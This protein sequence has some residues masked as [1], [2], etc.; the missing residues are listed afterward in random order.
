VWKCESCGEKIVI[1]S[2]RELGREKNVFF[3]ARHGEAGS[4]VRGIVSSYPEPQPFD[5]TEQGVREALRLAE[6]LKSRGGIDAIYASD[7]LR[8]KRTA[9][10][11]GG[12]LGIPVKFDS[13]LREYN[14]GIWNGKTTAEFQRGFPEAKRWHGAPEGGETQIE[15]ERRMASFVEE[16]NAAFDG[17]R[18][19][20]VS[21]G[22]PLMMLQRH[23]GS[24]RPY[25]NFADPFTLDVGVPDVH[26][27][28]IDEILLPCR[29]CGKKARRVSEIF[30]SWV[31]AGS[32]PFAEYHY[33]FDQKTV[34]EKRLPA[35]FVA[36]YIAQTRAWFYVMHVIS[37]I[38][39][40]KAPFENVVTTGTILAEDGSKMSKSKGNFPDPW[41]VIEKYGVD[42]L[43]FYLMGSVVMQAEN[44]NFSI[45]DLETAHRKVTLILWNVQ[46]YFDTYAREKKWRA[47]AGAEAERTVLD[48]W[49]D[50]RTRELVSETTAA[51]EGYDTVRATR[52]I[53]RYVDDLSTWY[54]RRSR[55]RDDAAFFPTLYGALR[56]AS[57]VIAP[58]M[59]YTAEAMHM[60]LNAFGGGGSESVHLTRWPD[61]RTLNDNDRELLEK[62]AAVRAAASAGLALRKSAGI[63][64][65]QPLLKLRVTRQASGVTIDD[66]LL[67]ILGDEVN[68]RVVE[69]YKGDA[70]KVELDTVITPEL[71]R[72]GLI[73][74]LERAVQELRRKE[75]LKVGEPADL[76]FH[77][78]DAE[79]REI[80]TSLDR[81]KMYLRNVSSGEG[82][83]EITIGDKRIAL[84]IARAERN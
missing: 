73:R 48:H 57:K 54:L 38:L 10:I 30:D 29:K 68:V 79:L 13:R 72:E 77:T 33:P 22:D 32:M 8:T 7:L 45:R 20:V 18:I 27:P 2:I 70:D 17:K 61:E 56:T 36:E 16:I 31:E 71:H 51:F 35:Q 23:Y 42:S 84:K 26:R 40:G 64:V 65:R 28:F 39:F 59:P 69:F 82:D 63:P 37:F 25:P 74:H 83:E 21:H 60:N 19:L 75:G 58:V 44:L 67:K 24:E 47:D 80:A 11:V 46:K 62:M 66:A 14:V 4:N 81:K 43:R 50:A 49:I 53:S 1:G 55:G 6:E 78:A 9:E 76:F 15:V 34:F 52:A 12:A 3:F 5:L 41:N